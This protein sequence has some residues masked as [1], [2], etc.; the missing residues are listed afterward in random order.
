MS[1]ILFWM[2]FLSA[3]SAAICNDVLLQDGFLCQR[4]A[5]PGL[6]SAIVVLLVNPKSTL[7]P[8]VAMPHREIR[9]PG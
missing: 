1:Q 8:H 7:A 9:R 2:R 4:S 5:F 6:V 3:L